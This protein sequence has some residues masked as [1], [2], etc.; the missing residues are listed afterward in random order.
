MTHGFM[1][2]AWEVNGDRGLRP[3]Y[4]DKSQDHGVRLYIDEISVAASDPFETIVKGWCWSPANQIESLSLQ[5]DRRRVRCLRFIPRPDVAAVFED[6]RAALA[7]FI[8]R[9]RASRSSSGLQLVA[10]VGGK[11]KVLAHIPALPP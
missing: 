5:C 4:I 7:G 3:A 2:D 1:P 10:T 9:I 6:K 8:G 11:P